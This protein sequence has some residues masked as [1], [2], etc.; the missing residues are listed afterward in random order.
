M[1]RG[2]FGAY[3][4]LARE[5][6]E[7]EALWRS[8]RARVASPQQLAD[9]SFEY[10][11]SLATFRFRADDW[12][13]V[14]HWVRSRGPRLPQA[15][16]IDIEV[17]RNASSTRAF[18]AFARIALPRLEQLGNVNRFVLS[19][20]GE[21]TGS[22]F[23]RGALF[24]LA[25]DCGSVAG[26]G[27]VP[28]PLPDVLKRVV[29]SKK[30]QKWFVSQ[31][32]PSSVLG[33]KP[34]DR[35]IN[36]WDPDRSHPDY[37]WQGSGTAFGAREKLV[38]VPI[39][40]DL[41]ADSKHFEAA[42]RRDAEAS[43][44]NRTTLLLIDLQPDDRVNQRVAEIVGGWPAGTIINRAAKTRDRRAYFADL[45]ESKFV[46]SPP[47]RGA[48]LDTSKHWEA[49]ALGA[50]PIVEYSPTLDSLLKN[51]P[52]ISLSDWSGGKCYPA[53]LLEQY[54]ALHKKRFDYSKLTKAYWQRAYAR[55][56]VLS[57]NETA[58]GP[59]RA[60]KVAL[61]LRQAKCS[62][63]SRTFNLHL[64][65]HVDNFR[66]EARPARREIQ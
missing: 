38:Q 54:D 52:Y 51:L 53:K 23:H 2:A 4:E 63:S 26:E 30:L 19:T 49:L 45:A 21:S 11:R 58:S 50:I 14:E 6:Q 40:I 59:Q 44:S 31:H 27:G 43:Q 18:C 34:P 8:V 22:P 37:I 62:A 47:G 57:L 3:D 55:E 12:R 65:P 15:F 36:Q 66:P 7:P 16:G 24:P 1:A 10:L 61:L 32:F 41:G 60:K 46:M 17:G 39:G 35:Q 5:G 64:C 20:L 48:T 29:S 42:W 25:L 28:L 9:T 56:L 33:D 13:G